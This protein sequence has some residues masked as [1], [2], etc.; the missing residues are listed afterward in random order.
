M[1][2]R[3]VALVFF[4][5]AGVASAQTPSA[6]VA[7]PPATTAG[8]TA[9]EPRGFLYVSGGRRDPFVSLLQRGSDVEH[10]AVATRA[11]GLLGLSASEVTLKGTL[12]SQSGYVAI[13]Q[14]VDTKTYIVR[15]GERLMDGTVRAI[16]AD[17]VVILQQV[18][19][20]LSLDTQ[21]E[22]RKTLRQNEEAK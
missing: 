4:V 19:D 11:P 8:Q 6:A 2:P 18:T 12:V 17:A 9:L 22:V 15:P 16:T 3:F 5:M 10:S 14:G 20:S 1:S 7:Q 21:R 13:M